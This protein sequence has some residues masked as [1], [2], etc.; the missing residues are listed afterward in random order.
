MH[1]KGLQECVEGRPDK[2]EAVLPTYQPQSGELRNRLCGIEMN[3][4]V[5]L[6]EIL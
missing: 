2:L 5:D 1:F 6:L 4:E 3:G